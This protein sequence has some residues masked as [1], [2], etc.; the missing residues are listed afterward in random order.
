MLHV[1]RNQKTLGELRIFSNGS[2]RPTPKDDIFVYLVDI[3]VN[4]AVC[5]CGAF[6]YTVYIN[7]KLSEEGRRRAYNHALKH[8]EGRDWEQDDVQ[9]IESEAHS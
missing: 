3:P 9:T 2:S 1:T 8:I 6:G 7:A 5:P 4:E